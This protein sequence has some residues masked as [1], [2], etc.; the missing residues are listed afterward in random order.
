MVRGLFAFP[1]GDDDR[2]S[3]ERRVM[4]GATVVDN[5]KRHGGST[6]LNIDSNQTQRHEDAVRLATQCF[7]W[8]ILRLSTSV[9]IVKRRMDLL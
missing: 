9:P 1:R 4:V 8:S 6:K 5:C 2:R 7:A 3:L